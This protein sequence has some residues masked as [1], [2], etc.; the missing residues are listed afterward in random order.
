MREQAKLSSTTMARLNNGDNVT[1]DVLLR[2]CQVLG[3][4]IGDIVEVIPAN[5]KKEEA[6]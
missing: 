3:C 4:Q 1:T 6:A 2:I 5:E